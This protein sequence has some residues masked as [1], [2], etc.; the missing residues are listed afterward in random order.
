MYIH[1][2]VRHY[3]VNLFHP[4]AFLSEQSRYFVFS[5]LFL[6]DMHLL[7]STSPGCLYCLDLYCLHLDRLFLAYQQDFFLS[8]GLFRKI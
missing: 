1:L 6:D 5:G 4:Q 7:Y 3:D 2:P 8:A